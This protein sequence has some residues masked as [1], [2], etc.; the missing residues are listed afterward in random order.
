MASVPGLIARLHLCPDV[1]PPQAGAHMLEL[2]AQELIGIT[3]RERHAGNNP[4]WMSIG[5]TSVW[6]F[7]GDLTTLTEEDIMNLEVQPTRGLPIPHDV[8]IMNKRKLVIAIAAS[9]HFS[10]L[11]AA[12]IDMRFFPG[13]LFDHFRISLYRHDE[14]IILCQVE[15][16]Y[17][18]NAKASFLKSI[19]PNA[20]QHKRFSDDKG[21]LTFKE[22]TKATTL[23]LKLLEMI[24]EPFTID[25]VTGNKTPYE[26]EDYGLDEMQPVWFYKATGAV[27][28]TPVARKIVN[29]HRDSKDTH[30]I[31]CRLC[32][33]YKNSVSSKIYSQELLRHA[34]MTNIATSNHHGSCQSYIT[35]FAETICQ[36]QALENNDTANKC[37]LTF[38]TIQWEEQHISKASLMPAT[39]LE[40]HLNITIPKTSLSKSTSRDLSRQS[41]HMTC[42]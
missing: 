31:W 18:V 23:P 13:K 21:W 4:L 20:K 33:H 16:P 29:Q 8:P 22:A 15:L 32:T 11:K 27:C 7:L 26:P 36:H 35:T 34:H 28:Q 12:S 10:C 19:K 17:Q 3:G 40:R 14:K 42:P 30:M 2:I 39:P 1:V 25:Q 41:N 38:S 37:V 6:T 24:V 5:A 9:H